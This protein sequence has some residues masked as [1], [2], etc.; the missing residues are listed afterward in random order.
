MICDIDHFKKIN[1][2]HCHMVG[3]EVLCGFV[4]LLYSELRQYDILGRW[5]GEEFIVISP[6]IKENNINMLCERL[7][8]AVADKPINTKAGNVSIT[9]S[10]GAKIWLENET[11]GEMLTAADAALYQAKN[12]GRNQ[13]CISGKK[14]AG[15][16]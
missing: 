13:I 10:I 4:R 5:G 15:D 6:G 8:S 11:S 12:G 2:A 1:D 7:R 9:I 16:K 14:V 3:D